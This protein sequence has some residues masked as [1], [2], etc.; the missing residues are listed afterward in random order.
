MGVHVYLFKMY[1]SFK[2]VFYGISIGMSTHV[3]M[4]LCV[5][6]CVCVFFQFNRYVYNLFMFVC[7]EF[8]V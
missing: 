3:H 4:C 5:F 2:C 7:Y 8:K 1:V 6:A